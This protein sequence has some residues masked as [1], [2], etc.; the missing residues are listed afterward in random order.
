MNYSLPFNVHYY[1]LLGSEF[2]PVCD[3]VVGPEQK[4]FLMV[5]DIMQDKWFQ[6]VIMDVGTRF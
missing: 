5:E 6:S 3:C 2:L 1:G 4:V